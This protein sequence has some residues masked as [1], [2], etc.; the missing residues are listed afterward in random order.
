MTWPRFEWGSPTEFLI[1]PIKIGWVCTIYRQV[2]SFPGKNMMVQDRQRVNYWL[3][4][5]IT[6]FKE[7]LL[8]MNSTCLTKRVRQTKWKNRRKKMG[9]ADCSWPDPD[10]NEG[11]PLNVLPQFGCTKSVG[12]HHAPPGLIILRKEEMMQ[13]SKLIIECLLQDSKL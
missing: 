5:Y 2:L 13:D 8:K 1:H 6:N 11:L 12:V 9:L 4:T 7:L 3:Y 10:S